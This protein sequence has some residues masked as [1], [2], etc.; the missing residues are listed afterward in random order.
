MTPMPPVSPCSTRSRTDHAGRCA[1][2][3]GLPGV[4][5][6]PRH[7]DHPALRT[8][9]DSTADDPPDRGGIED[10]PD[11]PD[12]TASHPVPQPERRAEQ[13]C[14]FDCGGFRI[15]AGRGDGEFIPVLAEAVPEP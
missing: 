12:P 1:C 15:V 7:V 13:W 9:A 11:G 4:G 6:N 14:S 2:V 3:P 5:V 8:C 10:D